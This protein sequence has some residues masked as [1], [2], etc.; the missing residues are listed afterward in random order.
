MRRFWVHSHLNCFANNFVIDVGMEY[1]APLFFMLLIAYV[2][3][4]IILMI[5]IAYKHYKN[6]FQTIILTNN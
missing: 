2:F 5:E 3:V 6:R 4:L 1:A